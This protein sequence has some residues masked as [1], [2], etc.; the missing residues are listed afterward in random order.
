MFKNMIKSFSEKKWFAFK[1]ELETEIE[2]KIMMSSKK[3]ILSVD[4]NE[5]K[6][7]LIANFKLEPIE[8]INEKEIIEKPKKESRY[9]KNHLRGKKVKIN[10][11]VFEI[12]YP[13]KGNHELF[14]IAP[15]HRTL[16][17]HE[18][19]IDKGNNLVGFEFF[20]REKDPDKFKKK[21]ES[22]FKDAFT[23]VDNINQEVK[24]WNENLERKVETKFNKIKTE[25]KKENDFFEAINLEV[26]KDTKNV[27]SAPTIEKKTVPQPEISDKKKFSSEPMMSMEMYEDVLEVIYNFGKSME[28][29]PS[30]YREKDEE[31]LRDLF[32]V[33]LGTRYVGATATGETFNKSGKTDILL[34]YSE[35]GS[36]LFV[37]EC[38]FWAGPKNFHD[39]IN[40]L[41]DRYLTWRDSKAAL[42]F[43]VD[44]KDFKLILEK[45]KEEAPNHKYFIEKCGE[46]GES[47]FSY[48]FLLPQDGNK[49]VYLEIM[50]FHFNR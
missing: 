31:D 49:E 45:I 9:V 15:S 32:L 21:K 39:A 8:I 46:K 11:Y 17:S 1:E 2:N 10:G 5:Y 19:F 48:K 43:F 20:I 4:E 23:N 47:S 25:Y 42:I 33:L 29:K 3:Y 40:Q 34:K 13:F 18:I 6:E 16:T 41:F 12:K 22:C 36:N 30:L 28:K 27:F 38:K 35:D 37:A 24:K 14:K 50:I 44:R 26:D 7:Y